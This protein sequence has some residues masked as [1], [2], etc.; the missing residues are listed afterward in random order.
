MAVDE[1]IL[2]E[3]E[4]MPKVRDKDSYA[5]STQ[6][7]RAPMGMLLDDDQAMWDTVPSTARAI[8]VPFGRFSLQQCITVYIFECVTILI[9]ITIPIHITLQ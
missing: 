1:A 4:A 2:K 5:V 6:V 7:R 9:H 3:K 8:D